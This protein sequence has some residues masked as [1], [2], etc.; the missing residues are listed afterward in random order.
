MNKETENQNSSSKFLRTDGGKTKSNAIEIPSISLPKGGG[1]IKGIDEKFTVNPTTGTA[2]QSIPIFTSHGRSNFGPKLS[3]NYNSG[4]G[5][6]PFGLGWNLDLPAIARKTD[7]G[8]PQYRDAEESDTFILSGAED[9]VPSLE[10][11]GMNW[12]RIVDPNREEDGIEYIVARYRPRIEGLFAR[13]EQWQRK[14]DGDI[15]W[16]STSKGNITTIY[17]KSDEC[18]IANPDNPQD[19]PQQVFKWLIEESYDDKGNVIL[20][21]YKQEDEEELNS[22][23]LYLKNRLGKGYA[24]RYIKRIKYCNRNPEERDRWLMK[25]VFDYGDHDTSGANPGT[26]G[27][28][29]LRNDPFSS[30]RSG[31]EIRTQ[32]LCERI[33]I[34]HHFEEELGNNLLVKS[35]DFTYE[36]GEAFTYL[37]AATQTGYKKENG[38][39]QTKSFPPIEFGYS[40][41]EVKKD[42]KFVTLENL[43][44][45]PIGVDGQ[46]YQFVDIYGEGISGI[47]SV[48]NGAWYYK[49]N[50]GNDDFGVQTV[51]AEKPSLAQLQSG[52][53]QIMDLAGDGTK[54]VV[55]YD[56]PVPGFYEHKD[57][58]GW[59]EFRNFKSLPNI[60]WKDPN[61]RFVD[62]NGDGHVDILITEDEVFTWY[63]SKAEDG[64]SASSYIRKALDEENGPTLVLADG[65]QSIFLSDMSGDGLTDLVRIRNGEICYWPNQGY[66]R[67]GRKV[68]MDNA[69]HF[70]TPDQFNHSRLRLADIDGT[71]TTDIFY[72]SSEGVKFWYN[73][74]GNS[75]ST[76]ETFTNFPP[77]NNIV[78]VDIFDLLGTGTA[79]LVWSSP[80]PGDVGTQMRYIDFMDSKKPHLLESVN[81]NMGKV[82]TLKY[83][84]STKF[85]LED[86]AKGKKWITKLP[87]PVHV[88]ERVEIFDAISKNYFVSRYAYHHGYF[89][90][91][92]REFRGFGR[93]E[94]WDTED[95]ESFKEPPAYTAGNDNWQE[96]SHLALVY[97]QSWFHTGN[98]LSKDKVSNFYKDDPDEYFNNRDEWYLSDTIMPVDL[99]SEE[100]REA[101]R[102]MNGSLLRQ[103]IYKL[104]CKDKVY[105]PNSVTE[106]SFYI[107]KEQ[108]KL[109]NQ[110]AVFN[111]C[112]W[113]SLNFHYEW[114]PD[115]PNRTYFK[116]NVCFDPLGANSLYSWELFFHAPLYIATWLSKNGKYEEAMKWFHYIFNPSTDEEPEAGKEISHYWKVLPFKTEHK[117]KLEDWFKQLNR[118]N[119]PSNPNSDSVSELSERV[120]E[121]RDNPFTPHLVASNRPLAYMKHV[122]IKY[123]ENLIAWADSLFR[124]FS[125]E[126]L[127][128]AIQIYVIANQVL[129]PRPEFVPN[130]RVIKTETYF[131]FEDKWDYFSNALDQLENIFPFS[132]KVSVIDSSTGTSL[133]GIGSALFFY[134]SSNDKL[135]GYWDI[136]TDRLFK[137]RHCQDIDGVKRNLVLFA[138]PIDPTAL[139]NA[140]SQRMSG[141]F[142]KSSL[143]MNHREGKTIIHARSYVCQSNVELQEAFKEK[144][145]AV[146][147]CYR[148][149]DSLFV[150]D[151]AKYAIEYNQQIVDDNALPITKYALFV[152]GTF[153]AAETNLFDIT[154]LTATNFGAGLLAGKTPTVFNL[155]SDAG[156][157]L[158][159]FEV[160]D[161][162]N[163]ITITS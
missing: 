59:K 54:D 99:T 20:Y 71:G 90:G 65:T 16:R 72:F 35:T 30:Y 78:S 32:R 131:S 138:P 40:M 162:T 118:E 106:N 157:P 149:A 85:Y 119:D 89:D 67:F 104:D 130:R 117:E 83:V 95:F 135:L 112:S 156:L 96:E 15:H 49:N 94:Q 25:V 43:E 92:E 122:V 129:G 5:N 111:V 58:E 155:I 42:I 10:K 77:I 69:P 3:L 75:W 13:I 153:A 44:N 53:G 147:G 154:I 2:T 101:C 70:D 82:T 121:W 142:P 64:F 27:N 7:K 102:A 45:L 127:D 140:S 61:L 143:V 110:H 19:K 47:L 14:S 22:Q 80:L 159:G 132:S 6:G 133:L 73:R 31:F 152:K 33:L 38:T 134:I 161:L 55:F 97:T 145:Q 105:L 158:L 9:L 39:Y 21:A 1:A 4:S 86:K 18:R 36:P 63:P 41:P 62:L 107:R 103:E 34:F 28:W 51:I 24:N 84:S 29:N 150:T 100:E 123:V 74:A 88:L 120:S 148:E 81:N 11:N 66:G 98:Y 23:K 87:F 68:G 146:V 26:E 93:V 144:I 160:E 113:E 151:L 46:A 48:Q 60:N 141:R 125:R 57:D 137:I 8:I 52:Q 109:I 50:L 79:C 124:Q 139:I 91:I 128:E 37:V 17:G 136:V 116:E 12:Q 108:P 114:D 56:S 163:E 115:D 126:S 76:E